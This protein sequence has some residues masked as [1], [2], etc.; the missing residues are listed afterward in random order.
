MKI[1]IIGA[2]QIGATLAA[3][4]IR[5]GHNVKV[6]NAR[7]Q[8]RLMEVTALTGAAAVT[9]IDVTIGVDVLVVSIP[10]LEIPNLASALDGMISPATVII[11]TTN[12]YP[13]RDGRVD[14]VEDGLPESIWVS[15][16][17]S[18]RVVKAY[19]S[20]LAGS[21]VKA[22]RPNGSASRIA[23]P[24]SGD[25]AG[26]KQKAM[27]LVNNSGFDAFDAGSLGASWRQQPGSPAYC[28]D[29]SL[30]A[31]IN[32]L[33]LAQRELLPARRET[34]LQFILQQNPDHWL[35]WYKECVAN[36]RIIFETQPG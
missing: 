30:A 34:A 5:A 32:N 27:R 19:N 3:Q 12:Y 8:A 13:I 33:P 10:F 23:L 35:S 20:I 21:L 11:D 26:Q 15:Q 17:L 28:T 18:H 29:L 6:A 2:G 31:L 1:G 25:D 9:L 16:Q 7:N 36:N 22:G 24:V 4:Y 14:A